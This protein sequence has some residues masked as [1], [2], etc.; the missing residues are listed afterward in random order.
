MTLCNFTMLSYA[1]YRYNFAELEPLLPVHQ[2]LDAVV[3][4]VGSRLSKDVDA[5]I[6]KVSTTQVT[7]RLLSYCSSLK[8]H[9][10]LFVCCNGA[11]E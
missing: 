5:P 7:K 10:M 2:A 11:D 6:K 3:R 1:T 4:L 9:T 8:H